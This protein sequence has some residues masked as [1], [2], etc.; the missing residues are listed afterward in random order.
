MFKMEM[1]IKVWI[2]Q[3]YDILYQIEKNDNFKVH[4][5]YLYFHIGIS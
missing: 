3:S 1:I 5:Y 2:S 4:L